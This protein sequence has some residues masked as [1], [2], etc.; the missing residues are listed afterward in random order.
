[1]THIM[2]WN[3][4]FAMSPLIIL[5]CA[6][7]V[8]M[9]WSA[10]S[11]RLEGGIPCVITILFLL[12]AL[13]MAGL[14]PPSEHPLLTRWVS[15]DPLARMF[16]FL[17]L[18]VGIVSAV[19]GEVALIATGTSRAEYFFFLVT[20]VAGLLL[21]GMAADLLTLF[22]GL[23]ILSLSLYVWCGIVRG[24]ERGREAA[25]KYFFS[26]ALATVFLLYGIAMIYGG[27]GTTELA[28]LYGRFQTLST[29]GDTFLFLG[30]IGLLTA[31]LAFKGALFPFHAWAPDVYEGAP[32]PVTAFMAIGT[33]M[34]AFAALARLFLL[35]LPQFNL[36]WSSAV[37]WLAILTMG[38]ANL[39]A[40]RQSHLRR[41]FA[42]SGIS[43]AGFMMLPLVVGGYESLLPLS[44]YLVVYGLATLAAFAVVISIDIGEQGASLHDLKG[45]WFRSPGLSVILI[46]ALLTLAGMPPTIGFFAKFYLF[47]MALQVGNVS[48]V[49]VG[50]LTTVLSAFYY[51]RIISLLFE[52]REP[53]PLL[54]FWP[55]ACMSAPAGICLCLFS[56]FPDLLFQLLQRFV[57]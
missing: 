4:C 26:G 15:F 33:K 49:V 21:I 35:A 56:L 31:S 10:F 9:L 1:M 37:A 24:W 2:T 43:H 22:L 44:L 28:L 20:S 32:T 14:A 50:L 17:F 7:L 30:G 12:C 55:P 36:L 52:E 11:K 6:A 25:M 3:D 8:L 51:L 27:V 47:Q 19:L 13:G 46:L 38:Y 53:A 23:E 39:L 18:I 40:L 34:G 29:G 48:L 42:Y 5:L 54:S 16:I 57:G 41:F 45:L